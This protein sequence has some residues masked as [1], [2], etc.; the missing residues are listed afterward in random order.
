MGS[1]DDVADAAIVSGRENTM[2]TGSGDDVVYASHRDVVIGGSGNDSAYLIEDGD[3]RVAGNDGFDVFHVG[4]SGN[5]VLGGADDDVINVLGGA[6]V[7]YLRG[8]DGY[9]AFWLVSAAGDRPAEAQMV[10]DFNPEEDV[11]G[12][13]GVSYES[14]AFE[15]VG[16]DTRLSVDGSPVGLFKDIDSSTLSDISHFAGLLA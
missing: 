6:G 1:G 12:L 13:A 10:M 2:F 5:R 8:G 3:N 14:L 15:Q 11:V 16:R 7:N 9:D 4:T